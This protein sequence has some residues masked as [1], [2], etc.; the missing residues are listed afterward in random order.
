MEYQFYYPGKNKVFKRIKSRY[1]DG[2]D[3]E[4]GNLYIVTLF[5]MVEQAKISPTIIDLWAQ[6]GKS[7]KTSK[8]QSTK[9]ILVPSILKED[10]SMLLLVNFKSINQLSEY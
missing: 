4:E 9:H 10:K 5:K 3:E 7:M 6:K 1:S 2:S 8:D